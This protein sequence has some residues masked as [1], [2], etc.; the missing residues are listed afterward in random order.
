MQN[1]KSIGKNL[2][3]LTSIANAKKSADNSSKATSSW[4]REIEEEKQQQQ[5][6][7]Q[8]E[9]YNITTNHSGPVREA[10]LSLT[11]NDSTT[12]SHDPPTTATSYSAFSSY[13][14]DHGHATPRSGSRVSRP[15]TS[16][17]SHD[18][19]H[20]N[21]YHQHHQ[22]LQQQQNKQQLLVNNASLNEY[23]RLQTDRRIDASESSDTSNRISKIGSTNATRSITNLGTSTSLNSSRFIGIDKEIGP[24]Q[25]SSSLIAQLEPIPLA[26]APYAPFP[27]TM[28][29][30]GEGNQQSQQQYHDV[31][32]RQQEYKQMIQNSITTSTTPESYIT[33]IAAATLS[34]IAQEQ[35]I[36]DLEKQKLKDREERQKF[37][38]FIYTLIKFI[39]ESS[40]LDPSNNLIKVQVRQIVKECTKN[41][42]MGI[43]HYRPLVQVIKSKLQRIEGIDD[44]WLRT[45]RRLDQFWKKRRQTEN[46]SY[47]KG[48]D[49]S[50]MASV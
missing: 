44:H 17:S 21:R 15:S 27:I 11:T 28:L 41:H 3:Y 34:S 42:R 35:Q 40:T 30:G 12:S 45:N 25:T 50:F 26:C 9:N 18:Y 23:D 20:L 33:N 47:V 48:E 22:Q 1:R 7:H 43:K 2:K 32:K 10:S 6:L 24:N 31:G 5:R 46:N 39:D 19:H 14:Q 38:V 49:D 16:S 29:S 36:R 13:I 37:L 4:G 8:N